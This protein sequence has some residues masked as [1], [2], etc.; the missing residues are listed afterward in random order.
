M[1]IKQLH[2]NITHGNMTV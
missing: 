1:Y 2:V